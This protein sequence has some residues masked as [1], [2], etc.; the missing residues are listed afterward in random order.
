M[1]FKRFVLYSFKHS[2]DGNLLGVN[3]IECFMGV[4]LDGEILAGGFDRS[5]RCLLAG[6]VANRFNP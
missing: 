5:F 2:G 3:C 6:D 1:F 4:F